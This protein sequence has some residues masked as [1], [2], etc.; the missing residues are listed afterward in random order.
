MYLLHPSFGAASTRGYTPSE[1]VGMELKAHFGILRANPAALLILAPVILPEPGSVA[2][3]L[4]TQAR[5]LDFANTHLTGQGAMEV[6]ELVRLTESVCDTRGRLVVKSR[7]RSAD[8]TTIGLVV[9]Y[10]SSCESAELV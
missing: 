9:K 3:N 2:V 5:L 8:G 7:V 6:S 1:L 4:E 10:Q